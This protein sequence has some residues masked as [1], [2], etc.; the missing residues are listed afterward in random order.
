MTNKI[1]L[2]VSSH[3]NFATRYSFD[4]QQVLSK[5]SSSYERYLHTPYKLESVTLG[6]NFLYT[7]H[8]SRSLKEN[9]R[10]RFRVRMV[11][12]INVRLG[13]GETS[14]ICSSMLRCMLTSCGDQ[15]R[16]SNNFLITGSISSVRQH[17]LWSRN[18]LLYTIRRSS[19]RARPSCN[20]PLWAVHRGLPVSRRT[21]RRASR[22]AT[23]LND[24][25]LE[26][27]LAVLDDFSFWWMIP[28][29]SSLGQ[30]SVVD[31]KFHMIHT[32]Y[33]LIRNTPAFLCQ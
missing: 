10:F 18:G 14:P 15:H 20:G 12:E 28:T 26:R 6:L 27:N 31:P 16:Q 25:I 1:L 9:Q 33:T 7:Q 8:F 22:L 17:D 19:R 24:M 32:T 23:D 3:R 21:W 13:V 30:L 2:K 11:I 4:V 5:S 29:R